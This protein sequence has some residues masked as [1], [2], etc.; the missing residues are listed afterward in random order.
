MA[1]LA[2]LG[3]AGPRLAPGICMGDSGD[4][5]VACATLGITH[6]PGYT[7]Y[8]VVGWLACKAFAFADPAYVVTVAC[9]CSMV[10]ALALI[11]CLLTRLG[12]PVALAAGTPFFLILHPSVQTSL[13][14]PEVYAPSLLCLSG[15]V[16]ALVR[17]REE[18]RRHHLIASA[19]LLGVLI[20]SRPPSLLFAPGFAIALLLIERSHRRTWKQ[21]LRSLAT[22]CAA[23]VLPIVLTATAT[24]ALDSQDAAYNYITEYAA[25]HEHPP[26]HDGSPYVHTERARWLLTGVEYRRHL[27]AAVRDVPARLVYLHD[28]LELARPIVSAILAGLLIIGAVALLRRAREV[29]IIA[30]T[31]LIGQTVFL[32][33]YQVEDQAADVLPWLF[34]ATLIVGAACATVLTK[35]PTRGRSIVSGAIALCMIAWSAMSFL[36]ADNPAKSI[37]ATAYLAG[38]DFASLP[39]NAVVIADWW[40]PE[41]RPLWYARCV[42]TG[43]TDISVMSGPRQM[44][45]LLVDRVP[46]R[47]IFLTH[48]DNLPQ[49]WQVT[50]WNRLWRLDQ[51]RTPE[52]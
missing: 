6:P 39:P 34:S 47:P 21:A 41:T 23:L 38:V 25:I 26:Q 29:G 4:L 50:S 48:A 17:Y 31:I 7:A 5:Q 24:V 10:M 36:R 14:L 44:W 37:D 16:Y 51:P 46:D 13:V 40:G 9:L 19:A 22:A 42:Q 12:M 28:S 1:T 20:I 49:G 18:H 8:V 15:A 43:R 11:M 35:L 30:L 32:V 33:F 2:L 27:N 52:W 3:L 45:P